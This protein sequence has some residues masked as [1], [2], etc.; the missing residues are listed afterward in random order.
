MTIDPQQFTP[1]DLRRASAL[2][3]HYAVGDL[4]GVGEIWREAAETDAWPDLTGAVVAVFFGLS[5][6]LLTVEGHKRLQELTRA[7]RA[8]EAAEQANGDQ[9]AGQ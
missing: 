2:L 9:D 6:E 7:Y 1:T 5:P 8:A 3:A 4:A